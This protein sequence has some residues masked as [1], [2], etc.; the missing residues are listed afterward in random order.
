[1]NRRFLFLLLLGPACCAQAQDADPFFAGRVP[2][3]M[4]PSRVGFAPGGSVSLIHQDQWLQMPG[5]FRSSFLAAQWCARNN[6]KPVH[7]WLGLGTL[8]D[9]ERQGAD[10]LGG[11]SI[12]FTPAIH[13]QAG[14]RSFL[15]FGFGLRWSDRTIGDA[16]GAWASQYDG[17]QYRPERASGETFASGHRSWAESAAGLSFSLK[18]AKESRFRREP[19]VLV[20][21]IAADHLGHLVLHED[22]SPL[23]ATPMRITAYA[24]GKLPME[25]WEN[26]FLSTELILNW[27]QPM[28]T[29]RI[30]VFA[31]KDLLN[32][33]QSKEGP[34]ALGFKAGLG[35]RWQ[36]ALLV[37]AA[38]DW[39]RTTF[40]VAYGWSLFGKT[41]LTAGRRTFECVAQVRLL[42]KSE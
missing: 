27:Q 29:G 4:D 19:D 8:V 17:A 9:H 26:G 41:P 20:V 24:M 31:G 32:E 5:N 35:Y 10:G 28:A 11:S 22:G 3:V 13:L 18:E 33:V 34:S 2:M 6:R 12:T 7:S 30:N 16:S 14:P 25:I 40:G 38:L 21:G 39:G 15:S 23:A 37:N 42:G 36:D 1:M